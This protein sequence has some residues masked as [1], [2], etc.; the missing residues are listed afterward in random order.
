M[1]MPGKVRG[2][3]FAATVKI[4]VY[5]KYW[6]SNISLYDGDAII[7]NIIHTCDNQLFYLGDKMVSIK[8]KTVR[9]HHYYK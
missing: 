3:L 9:I 7:I 6:V 5:D 2:R 4:S 1:H 8:F